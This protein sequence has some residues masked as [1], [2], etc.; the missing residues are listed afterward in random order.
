MKDLTP[1]W[2]KTK[3]LMFLVIGGASVVLILIGMPDWRTAVLLA[4]AIW[5]FCRLYYFAFY[6]IEKYVDPGYKFS[7]LMSF[8]KY[9]LQRRR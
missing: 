3:A 8:V 1:F 6:V 7:G 5:S 2:I 9:L 4:L